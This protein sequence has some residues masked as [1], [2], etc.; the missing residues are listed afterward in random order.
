M[1]SKHDTVSLAMVEALHFF[2]P[3]TALIAPRVAARVL[4]AEA[5]AAIQRLL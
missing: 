1:G 5:G 4:A 3:P 2:A